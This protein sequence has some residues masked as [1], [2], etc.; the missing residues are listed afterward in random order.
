[1]AMAISKAFQDRFNQ[2]YTQT[3][4]QEAP[5]KATVAGNH[6]L[7]ALISAQTRA[8]MPTV[9]FSVDGVTYTELKGEVD[10]QRLQMVFKVPGPGVIAYQGEVRP[11]LLGDTFT[12]D[13][14]R[15][16]AQARRPMPTPDRIPLS[17][18]DDLIGV[19]GV[20]T[21]RVETQYL[22]GGHEIK[23]VPRGSHGTPE[24]HEEDMPDAIA[25]RTANIADFGRIKIAAMK[26]ATQ[27]SAYNNADP[28]SPEQL[29]VFIRSYQNMQRWRDGVMKQVE[30]ADGQM[31]SIEDMLNRWLD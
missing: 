3:M 22:D 14:D 24:I 1:M 29:A 19:R 23:F 5:M 2:I 17:V 10:N 11:A 31:E 6:G 12:I 8:S 18:E 7:A 16:Y 15:R 30:I 20:S 27:M 4:E 21:H 25:S 28:P 13:M 26:L 9:G